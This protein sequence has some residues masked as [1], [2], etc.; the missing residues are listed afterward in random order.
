MVKVLFVCVR[1]ASAFLRVKICVCIFFILLGAAPF[2][3]HAQSSFIK[4]KV[5]DSKSNEAIAGASVAVKARKTG[6]ITNDKG[7]FVLKVN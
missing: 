2:A 4:G 7:E 5:F 1:R 6:S 3:A